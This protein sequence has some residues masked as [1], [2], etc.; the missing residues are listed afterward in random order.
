MT[1]LEVNGKEISKSSH[2]L[3]DWAFDTQELSRI[4][5]SNL[6]QGK[7]DGKVIQGRWTVPQATPQGQVSSA[8]RDHNGVIVEWNLKKI[9]T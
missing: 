9:T 5:P 7:T 8:L 3:E 4:Y 2:E 6:F 1:T